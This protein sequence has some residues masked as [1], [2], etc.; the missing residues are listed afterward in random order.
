MSPLFALLIYLAILA[1]LPL[2]YLAADLITHDPRRR[3]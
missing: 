2:G 3:R 1:G